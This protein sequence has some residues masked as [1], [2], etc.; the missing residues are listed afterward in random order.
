MQF[1]ESQRLHNLQFKFQAIKVAVCESKSAMYHLSSQSTSWNFRSKNMH[2]GMIKSLHCHIGQ[3]VVNKLTDP[4]SE[5]YDFALAL[6]PSKGI[7][8]CVRI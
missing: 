3:N 5:G 8:F 4:L 7:K 1:E 6:S 2:F